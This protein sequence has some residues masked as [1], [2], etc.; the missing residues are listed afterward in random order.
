VLAGCHFAVSLLHRMSHGSIGSH[1]PYS[2]CDHCTSEIVVSQ[3]LHS[4]C[5][6]LGF[7]LVLLCIY[8]LLLSYRRRKR[9][10]LDDPLCRV[11]SRF[12]SRFGHSEGAHINPD[13]LR[14]NVLGD[15]NVYESSIRLDTPRRVPLYESSVLPSRR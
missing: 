14:G 11:R 7:L 9:P 13:R 12:R 15:A 10:V 5:C 3:C 6:S 4:C 8:H 2:S 1:L